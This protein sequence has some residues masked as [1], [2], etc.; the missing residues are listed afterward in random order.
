MGSC[1][2]YVANSGQRLGPQ[3]PASLKLKGAGHDVPESMFS[4]PFK[5]KATVYVWSK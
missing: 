4:C 3:P 5:Q 2:S 1:H